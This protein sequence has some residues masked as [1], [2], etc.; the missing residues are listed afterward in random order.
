MRES[1]PYSLTTGS[2]AATASNVT[3]TQQ[4]ALSPSRS[5]LHE[6]AFGVGATVSGMAGDANS[7]TDMDN[8]FFTSIFLEDALLPDLSLPAMA[9]D[10]LF[11][12]GSVD[13]LLHRP[14]DINA[15][16]DRDLREAARGEGAQPTPPMREDVADRDKDRG[17]SRAEGSGGRYSVRITTEDINTL[18]DN[19]MAAD[20]FNM[21]EDFKMPTVASVLRAI[22]AY[23]TYFDPHTPIIHWPSFS[24]EESHRKLPSV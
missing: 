13:P 11:D 1:P 18:E 15:A 4:Q 6:A 2:G 3:T 23:I 5:L 24:V 9:D 21:I 17:A 7:G 19:I 20:L 22:N 12:F 16:A 8:A 14:S 10:M